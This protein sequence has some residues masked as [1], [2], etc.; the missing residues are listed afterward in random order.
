MPSRHHSH[1]VH[2]LTLVA[3]YY[4][5]LHDQPCKQSIINEQ[6]AHSVIH[7]L[8][9]YLLLIDSGTKEVFFFICN[10]SGD[11]TWLE[12][13]AP[14]P[15]PWSSSQNKTNKKTNKPQEFKKD[16]QERECRQV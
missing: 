15:L 16:S 2:E 13:V 1:Y 9:N 11:S 6:R 5:S 8:L 12:W 4:R 7:L 10:S 3:T 14:N